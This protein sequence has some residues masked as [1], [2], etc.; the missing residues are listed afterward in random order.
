MTWKRLIYV[1]NALVDE[2]VGPEETHDDVWSIVFTRCCLPPSTR[3]TRP[4]QVASRPVWSSS[5]E[6][7]LRKDVS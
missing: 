3:K 5:A 6:D 7:P 1:A 4:A 2:P